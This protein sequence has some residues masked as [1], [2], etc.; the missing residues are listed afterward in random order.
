M[1]I[2]KQKLTIFLS[3]H[4]HRHRLHVLVTTKSF[5]ALN[6][7]RCCIISTGWPAKTYVMKQRVPV[8]NMKR[9]PHCQCLIVAYKLC[10]EIFFTDVFQFR[11]NFF[12]LS[13]SV[14]VC[15]LLVQEM[16]NRLLLLAHGY[17][18]LFVLYSIFLSSAFRQ[19][20]TFLFSNVVFVFRY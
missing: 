18:T 10:V 4:M 14:I 1:L 5:V 20:M 9:Q 17:F 3:L 16:E 2:N 8:N 6:N 13:K 12:L 11:F 15:G 19:F 7:D